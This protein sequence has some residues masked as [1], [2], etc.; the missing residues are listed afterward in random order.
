MEYY[1][2]EK[3]DYSNEKSEISLPCLVFI[4]FTQDQMLGIKIVVSFECEKS[5]QSVIKIRF[6]F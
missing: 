4:Y 1:F 6:S 2:I 3:N 5:K